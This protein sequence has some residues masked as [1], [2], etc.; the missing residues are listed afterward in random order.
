M[1]KAS[2]ILNKRVDILRRVYTSDSMGGFTYST[3]AT[4]VWAQIRSTS[5]S[6]VYRFGGSESN[7]RQKVTIR[8]RGEDVIEPSDDIK[9]GSRTFRIHFIDYQGYERNYIDLFCIEENQ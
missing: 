7:V 1:S 8:Y 5:G 3:V 2:P 6:E 4:G 9:Y